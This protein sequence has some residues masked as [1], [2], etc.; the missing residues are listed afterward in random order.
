MASVNPNRLKT[1][2]KKDLVIQT[3]LDNHMVTAD[4]QTIDQNQTV[5]TTNKKNN[6]ARSDIKIAANM[7]VATTLMARKNIESKANKQIIN[8]KIN[9]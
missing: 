6:I 4:N 1:E 3:N 7:I 9:R 8:K 2:L 5:F